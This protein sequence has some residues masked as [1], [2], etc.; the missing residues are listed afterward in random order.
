M[1][2]GSVPINDI[3]AAIGAGGFFLSVVDDFF[4][5]NLLFDCSDP[6]AR[7]RTLTSAA[8]AYCEARSTAFLP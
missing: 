5:L 6:V 3:A 4:K 7:T 1:T 2:T 8:L